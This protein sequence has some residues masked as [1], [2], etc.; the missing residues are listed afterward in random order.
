MVRQQ[1]FTP[2]SNV[3]EAAAIG[4]QAGL[5]RAMTFAEGVARWDHRNSRLELLL[6]QAC[7]KQAS[8]ADTPDTQARWLD[9]A[10]KWFLLARLACP[11][12]RGFPQPVDSSA[13]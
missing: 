10:A 6:G 5:E 7:L 9:A 11:L 12:G 3:S 13:G 2:N 4:S 1:L 8:V